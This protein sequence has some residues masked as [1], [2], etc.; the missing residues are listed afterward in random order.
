[1]AMLGRWNRPKQTPVQWM[2]T[3]LPDMVPTAHQVKASS[4]T[5][6]RVRGT[7]AVWNALPA[8]LNH[9]V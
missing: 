2:P 8:V 5:P 1:M 9:S 3:S 4:A 7:T 6:P